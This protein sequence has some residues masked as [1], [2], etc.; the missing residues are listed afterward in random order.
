MNVIW[1]IEVKIRT[2]D[3][4]TSWISLMKKLTNGSLVITP[5]FEDSLIK[6]I[7]KVARNLPFYP[8]LSKL[9]HQVTSRPTWYW[10][11]CFA[12]SILLPRPE[13]IDIDSGWDY[14]LVMVSGLQSQS[15]SDSQHT[16]E[17]GQRWGWKWMEFSFT[18]NQGISFIKKSYDIIMPNLKISL[19]SLKFDWWILTPAGQTWPL[20]LRDIMIWCLLW[21]WK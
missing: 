6:F 12:W 2:Y 5:F 18:E 17:L 11:T 7:F 19:I 4:V 20:N 8:T 16:L 9:C 3:F 13:K 21:C 15:V 1:R 10:L 14:V